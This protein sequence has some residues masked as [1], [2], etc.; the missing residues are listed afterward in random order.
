VQKESL[1]FTAI[2]SMCFYW[3]EGS[4]AEVVVVAVSFCSLFK[5]IVK[6]PNFVV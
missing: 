6:K 3:I 5:Q 1:H 4:W 2:L